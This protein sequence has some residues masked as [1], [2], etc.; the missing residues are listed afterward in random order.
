MHGRTDPVCLYA[1]GHVNKFEPPFQQVVALGTDVQV[2]QG[3]VEI[4]GALPF[5]R[6]VT[7]I[8]GQ[9]LKV[10]IGGILLRIEEPDLRDVDPQRAEGKPTLVFIGRVIR[11]RRNVRE[12]GHVGKTDGP[13]KVAIRLRRLPEER[14]VGRSRLAQLVHHRH[15]HHVRAVFHEPV[16][17]IR[18]ATSLGCTIILVDDIFRSQYEQ[19]V[20]PHRG[21]MQSVHWR[22]LL[23]RFLEIDEPCRGVAAFVD[24]LDSRIE[25]ELYPSQAVRLQVVYAETHLLNSILGREEAELAVT[26]MRRTVGTV[27]DILHVHRRTVRGSGCKRG[28]RHVCRHR[29]RRGAR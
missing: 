16:N 1:V 20:F 26:G 19:A 13:P 22:I 4:H 28:Q 12:L 24:Y 7:C 27:G 14:E 25:V 17:T 15:V 18:I 8:P 10:D 6:I 2:F 23:V 9:L 3:G 11:K 5:R 21:N 29:C